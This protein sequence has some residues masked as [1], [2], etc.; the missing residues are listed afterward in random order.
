MGKPRVIIADEDA[1][2]IVPLQF[3]F[4][5]DFFN[6]ID[7]EIIT[8][9]AYFEDYF[10]KPQNAEILIV[11]DMLYD[12]SLQRHNI[13]NIFVMSESRDEGQTGELSINR[14]FKYT[15]IKEIF[16]EIVGKSAGALNV[17]AVEKKET[18]IIA[19]AS[20]YGGAGKTL[21]SRNVALCLANN[22][23]KVLYLNN[24]SLQSF[25]H[26]FNNTTKLAINNIGTKLYDAKNDLYLELKHLLRTEG[27]TY[28]PAFKTSLMSIGLSKDFFYSF[29]EAA[30]KSNE[31]DYIVVD[32]ESVYD[33][34]MIK[35]FDL[36]EKVVI[37]T[38]QKHSAIEATNDL[39]TNISMNGN[40]K[41]IFI[42]NK[43]DKD[44]K[45]AL[46]DSSQELLFSISEYVDY[47]DDDLLRNVENSSKNMGMKKVS[48]LLM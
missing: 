20:G 29:A 24:S 11:S 25:Q 22:Y 34:M 18:Q 42:C 37:I 31:Y 40:D 12:S 36:S 19:F 32:L 1:G 3:K 21:I 48:F 39:V 47:I 27:F 13:Q 26:E 6:K 45:N 16:N 46:I 35:F 38:E 41:Y 4:V 23:K 2:Y 30:K 8:E 17:A 33:E 9:K 10:S 14:L 7:L 15:S 5:T 28:L 44:K 43:F